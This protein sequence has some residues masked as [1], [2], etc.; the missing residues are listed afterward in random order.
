ML[1]FGEYLPVV[2]EPGIAREIWNRFAIATVSWFV[3]SRVVGHGDGHRGFHVE[4]VCSLQ[5][6][7]PVRFI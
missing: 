6:C 4:K 3:A 7:L 5:S 1:G 2:F